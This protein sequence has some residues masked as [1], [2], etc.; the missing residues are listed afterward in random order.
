MEACSCL[1]ELEI[2]RDRFRSA[3]A[4]NTTRMLGGVPLGLKIAEDIYVSGMK[5]SPVVPRP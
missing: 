1:L 2:T 4:I 5:K 3:G